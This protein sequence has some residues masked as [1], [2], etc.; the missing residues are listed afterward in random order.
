M[1]RKQLIRFRREAVEGIFVSIGCIHRTAVSFWSTT[2]P[3]AVHLKSPKGEFFRKTAI[4][5]RADDER[6]SNADRFSHPHVQFS[7][8]RLVVKVAILAGASNE[9]VS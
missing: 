5:L 1:N 4:M 6:L 8:V 9:P 2:G 7:V 3:I